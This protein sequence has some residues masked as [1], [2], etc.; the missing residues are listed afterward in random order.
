MKMWGTG[1]AHLKLMINLT[2]SLSLFASFRGNYHGLMPF[3]DA[4]QKNIS[5]ICFQNNV[6]WSNKQ[7]NNPSSFFFDAEPR[8]APSTWSVGWMV[9]AL[10]K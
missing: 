2:I 4:S 10:F 6:L 1:V 5:G 8:C 7:N 3:S 9:D